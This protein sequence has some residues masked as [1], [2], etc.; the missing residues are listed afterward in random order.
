[1]NEDNAKEEILPPSNE[2][3]PLSNEEAPFN[4]KGVNSNKLLEAK[5]LE[6]IER[7][8]LDET[9]AIIKGMYD[10]AAEN[11]RYSPLNQ[12]FINLQSVLRKTP[13]THLKSMKGWK[14][15]E[16]KVLKGSKAV[17]V[18]APIT[19]K[20]K[21]KNADGE[22]IENPAGA[23]SKYA[24]Q[25]DD[26]GNIKTIVSGF[27]T[28]PLF[29]IQST[30]AIEKGIVKLKTIERTFTLSQEFMEDFAKKANGSDAYNIVFNLTKDEPPFE[31]QIEK[32]FNA[33]VDSRIDLATISPFAR[34]SIIYL[35]MQDLEMDNQAYLHMATSKIDKENILS[36]M[37]L[38]IKES[39]NI[40]ETLDINI[41][42]FIPVHEIESSES[43][44][45]ATKDV[46]FSEMF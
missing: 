27:K 45:N 46:D 8:T 3:L 33:V 22:A 29:A 9:Q 38:A 39:Q 14:N 15:D 2:D 26:E 44:K 37:K 36:D 31:V 12:I 40:I 42:D 24:Y 10:S 13:L 25:R 23:K 16:V 21:Q 5:I 1:M 17:Y 20:L 35:L 6:E 30:D 28:M 43:N 7:S 34:N 4:F 41:H 19:T 18:L 11:K 32:Y